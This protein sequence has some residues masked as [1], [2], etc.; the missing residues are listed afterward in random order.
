MTQ[1]RPENTH[2]TI[3]KVIT[4]SAILH[5]ED[6][7]EIGKVR[8]R[9]YRYKKGQGAQAVAFHYL[10]VA[11]ARVLFSDLA[12]GNLPEE[13]VDFKGSPTARDGKP[14]SRVLKVQDTA[15]RPVALSS[16]RP[17]MAPVSSLARGCQ[18]CRRTRRQSGHP[19]QPCRGPQDGLRRVGVSASVCCGADAPPR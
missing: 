5:L 11:D 14:L 7:L 12:Q 2:A 15:A 1:Q 13:F 16:S 8:L 18:T 6:A 4:R 19:D 9:L 10:D 3:Y 17:A